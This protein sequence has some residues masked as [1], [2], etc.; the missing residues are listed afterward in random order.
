M[1]VTQLGSASTGWW[2]WWHSLLGLQHLASCR[3]WPSARLPTESCDRCPV[4]ARVP[5]L[6]RKATST[7]A[8]SQQPFWGPEP[9]YLGSQS[10]GAAGG[11]SCSLQAQQKSLCQ[12]P[13][14]AALRSGSP[15][16]PRWRLK[17]AALASLH[18]TP[19]QSLPGL[20]P[21]HRPNLQPSTHRGWAEIR[22][23][24]GL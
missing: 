19:K 23:L 17:G 7:G 18:S 8:G 4:T 6:S 1:T 13:D 9:H 5:Q 16:Q 24:D 11:R 10:R 3:G 21:H 20:R 12:S 22:V 14:A 15:Q 2:G